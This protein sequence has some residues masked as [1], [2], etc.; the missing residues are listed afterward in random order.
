MQ[1]LAYLADIFKHLNELIP[2]CKERENIFMSVDKIY[3]MR[4]KITI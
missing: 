3:A 2:V 4:D 1:K